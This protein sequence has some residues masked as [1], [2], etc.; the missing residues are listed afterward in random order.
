MK[1]ADIKSSSVNTSKL[2]KKLRLAEVPNKER[3]KNESLFSVDD[4]ESF[5]N[6][7]S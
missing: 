4:E 3:A 1:S 7:S 5:N 2:I 6:I